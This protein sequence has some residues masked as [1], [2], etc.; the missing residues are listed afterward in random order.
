MTELRA[1]IAEV[2]AEVA[3]QVSD[4]EAARTAERGFTPTREEA[5]VWGE[6]AIVGAVE[7]AARRRL[8][9]AQSPL[10][11]DDEDT[12]I[13]AVRSWV[14]GHGRLDALLAD[15]RVE[16]I[17][18]NGH[19]HVTITMVGGQR[20]TGPP[21]A[22][23]E[24]ELE[25]LIR[26]W[27]ATEG[28]TERRFDDAQ[29]Y[30]DLRLPD[31]SRLH[32]I[33]GVT[34][35][36]CVSI[37]KHRHLRVT[38]A[39]LVDLGTLDAGLAQMLSAAIRPPLPCSIVI[40]GGTD[41]GKTTFAR[42]LISE[43]PVTERLV[44]IED[45][46]ELGLELDPARA[47]HVVEMEVRQPNLEGKGGI[48]MDVL[49][50]QALRMRPDRL[51][52]GECRSGHEVRTMLEAMNSGHEG[53][54]TTIH[55]DSSRSAL[56]KMQ[57]YALTG[58]DALSMEASSHLINLV[59]HLVLHLQKTPDGR[60]IVT[61]VR[62]ITGARDGQI[63]TNEV[64][65]SPDPYSPAVPTSAGFTPRLLDRLSA[66]GTPAPPAGAGSGPVGNGHQ[67]VRP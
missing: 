66:S 27:A 46:A 57:T 24:E 63:H 49:G 59:L 48:G 12:V 6:A 40:A 15:D 33:K 30:L 28:K 47:P 13:D 42:A 14:F 37:R 34:S 8:A 3:R 25:Q 9:S 50:R 1:V 10:S 20:V 54:L 41:T 52:V 29:P 43:I 23:S 55:A 4:W 53:S 32:A 2:R 64:Y 61:S 45:N 58:D 65:A 51:I 7:Q 38:L 36:L 17:L 67:L 56:T 60:R 26:R 11:E 44:V 5:T 39:E 18:A 35:R 19:D 21:L 16:N 62:E 31:G 22:D